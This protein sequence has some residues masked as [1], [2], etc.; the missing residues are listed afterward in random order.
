MCFWC[1]LIFSNRPV[2]G[3]KIAAKFAENLELGGSQ[4]EDLSLSRLRS[5]AA[6][7]ILTGTLESAS[8]ISI[9]ANT[10]PS[11]T[12]DTQSLNTKDTKK[13]SMEPLEVIEDSSGSD[14]DIVYPTGIKFAGFIMALTLGMIFTGLVRVFSFKI[15]ADLTFA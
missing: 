4:M 8:N 12:P 7:H 3:T 5:T 1:S 14:G 6:E 13:T 10:T 15:H 9:A 11:T 2:L